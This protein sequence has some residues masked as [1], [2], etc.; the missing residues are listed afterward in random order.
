MA[1]TQEQQM[2]AGNNY[3]ALLTI[4]EKTIDVQ[5]HFN[6]I[7]LR[8]RNF[9]ILLLSAFVGGVGVSIK[10]NYQ[11][12]AFGHHIAVTSII[13]LAGAFIWSA[14]YFM[15]RYWY[16]PLLLGAV[17]HGL[18]V[19]KLLSKRLAAAGLTDSEGDKRLDAASLTATIGEN[20]PVK[21][22]GRW[23]LHS[24]GKEHVFYGGIFIVLLVMSGVA[25]FA[26]NG[27]RVD[28][29]VQAPHSSAH[30]LP[31]APATCLQPDSN[32]ASVPATASTSH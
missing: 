23:E 21:L 5:M 24:S 11:I 8:I 15:D 28:G 6:D 12:T 30:G 29:D 20:S 9:S 10:E 26:T 17:K 32:N 18:T 16:H 27:A 7:Q 31:A 13:F 19:E 3:D 2:T 4:W 1:Q 22:L 25:Y 14:F